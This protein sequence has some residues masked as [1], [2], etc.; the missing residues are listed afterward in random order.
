M[1]KLTQI[2]QQK[3]V[4]SVNCAGSVGYPGGGKNQSLLWLH[5]RKKNQ[6]QMDCKYEH[7]DQTI[8]LEMETGKYFYESGVDKALLNKKSTMLNMRETKNFHQSTTENGKASYKVVEQSCNTVGH[9][10]TCNQ[11]V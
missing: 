4:L 7:K 3:Y 8:C 5:S 1:I 10:E 11:K 9:Q 2:G 6:F